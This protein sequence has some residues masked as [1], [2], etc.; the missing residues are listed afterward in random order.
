MKIKNKEF[1]KSFFGKLYSFKE[2]N[3]IKYVIIVSVSGAI[4]FISSAIEKIFVPQES[5]GLKISLIIVSLAVFLTLLVFTI[6]F[7]ISDIKYKNYIKRTGKD[8]KK[9]LEFALLLKQNINNVCNQKFITLMEVIENVKSG[10]MEPPTII[11]KPCNQLR[12]ITSAIRDTFIKILPE[13]SNIPPIDDVNVQLFYRYF[14]EHDKIWHITKSFRAFEYESVDD[15][16]RQDSLLK[17]FI[18]GNQ[19]TMFKNN[20]QEAYNNRE[21]FPCDRDQRD[22]KGSLMGSIVYHKIPIVNSSGHKIM[23]C[24]VTV[25]TCA[26]RFATESNEKSIENAKYNIDTI[27]L[28]FKSR[29][30]IEMCL[31]YLD[32]LSEN[33]LRNKPNNN[34]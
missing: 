4:T 28:N 32:Y 19:D 15:L 33:Y 6:L 22:E 16:C 10:K 8:P 30:S 7:N 9:D 17:K 29:I 18:N 23:E 14:D 27:M 26:N 12:T 1:Q 20:K 2:N 21:Y 5:F 13:N 3:P 31:H 11:N 34:S 25:Y 24:I